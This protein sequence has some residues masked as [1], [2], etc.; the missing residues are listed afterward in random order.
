[1]NPDFVEPHF[2]TKMWRAYLHYLTNHYN[3]SIF[4]EICK[5]LA[6]P[7]EYL[8]KDGNWVSNQFTTQFMMKLKEK[9][10]DQFIAEKVGRFTL[11]PDNINTFEF[12]VLKA[13][14]PILFFLT[15]PIQA[16]KL[17]RFSSFKVAKYRPGFV[18]YVIKPLVKGEKY[19]QDVCLNTVGTLNGTKELYGLDRVVVD[20]PTCIHNGHDECI[21]EVRFSTNR[22]WFRTI[23][24]TMAIV[25]GSIYIVKKSSGNFSI[26]TMRHFFPILA[27]AA[28]V[29]ANCFL[30]LF[31]K[32]R[33]ILIN[34]RV[35]Q[36]QN[37]IKQKALTENLRKLDRRYQESNLLRDLSLRLIRL[38][39]ARDVISS[40]L[41]DLQRRFGYP[42][43]L[44]M[45]VSPKVG[46]LQAIE[47]RGFEGKAEK[48]LALDF[49]YP[50]EKEDPQ[51]FANILE[52]GETTFM[53]NI[54][55]LKGK[56]KPQNKELLES[57]KV[58]SLVL[59]P[60]QSIEQ[61]YGLLIIGSIIGDR[62]LTSDDRHLM[63][64]LSRMLSLFFQNAQNFEQE[65]TLRNLFQKY[66]PPVVLESIN[67]LTSTSDGRLAPKT[68]GI[69]S[70]FTDLRGF[71]TLSE[72][73]KPEGVFDI[74]NLYSDYIT[75]HIA[76]QGGIVD[77]LIGDGVVAF[78]PASD[79]DG[80][81]TNHSKKA[82]IASINILEGLK[83]FQEKL[84]SRGYPPISV[85]I[86]LHSGKAL[87]GNIGGDI[88]LNYTA[89]GDTVNLASRLQGHSKEIWKSHSNVRGVA[90]L[91]ETVVRRANI[92]VEMDDLNQISVRGREGK[93]RVFS[94]TSEQ[95]EKTISM[96]LRNMSS[97]RFS[98]IFSN[99]A[100]ST[101][102]RNRR[103]AG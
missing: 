73:I 19:G 2:S 52:R 48:L 5:E 18:R 30:I 62:K 65:K 35:N 91:S 81:R 63:E 37:N 83:E 79:N 1:M 78:F 86:G 103:K 24:L 27:G 33:N 84:R 66:V 95:A 101:L 93:V 67:H 15:L 46:R 61:K 6:M 42:R 11:N 102:K 76:S 39:S 58:D 71:T 17:N 45:L 99:S 59:A 41:D 88:K 85:G 32:I 98:V 31:W 72:K 9:T 7:E 90:I 28:Y 75:K 92:D 44:V 34:D 74:L 53:E 82:L 69:T 50:G 55:D 22:F 38:E 10:G 21:F 54:G 12:A 57:L 26:E 70:L 20:H 77:N 43:L 25:L 13:M 100:L 96:G 8:S 89:I 29:L 97:E 36:E 4:S 16:G 56:I 49:A 23:F 40:C 68:I 3:R 80:E 94:I 60:I 51:L 87:V 14:P 64:N 47:V